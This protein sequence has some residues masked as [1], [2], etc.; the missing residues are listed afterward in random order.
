ML[1]HSLK[2][3]KKDEEGR[4]IGNSSMFWRSPEME[5]LRVVDWRPVGSASPANRLSANI[6]ALKKVITDLES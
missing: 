1:V 4:L 2:H 3:A 6:G 5:A